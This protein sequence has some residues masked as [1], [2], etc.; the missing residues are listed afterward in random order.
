V[1][2]GRLQSPDQRAEG[3]GKR[4]EVLG[5][6]GLVGYRR[7]GLGTCGGL[8]RCSPARS[9]SRTLERQRAVPVS[10]RNNNQMAP[11]QEARARQAEPSLEAP[12][13]LIPGP[14][15]QKPA[16]GFSR[17]TSRTPGYW[18]FL[19]PKRIQP[20]N[21]STAHARTVRARGDSI[22]LCTTC[23]T[24]DNG[25]GLRKKASAPARRASSSTSFEPYEVS[26]TIRVS[27]FRL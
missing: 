18:A 6:R 8:W 12:V 25:F 20:R 5:G 7:F 2:E 15:S 17:L 9:C 19:T 10:G 22:R 13:G 21:A 3:A 26:T 24:C 14:P 1:C 16:Q 27:G 4:R 11:K 23:A